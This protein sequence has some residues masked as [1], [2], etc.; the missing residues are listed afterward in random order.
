MASN[1]AIWLQ[2]F[3]EQ[4][5]PLFRNTVHDVLRLTVSDNASVK[6]LADAILRDMTL[7]A[8]VLAVSNSSLY[9]RACPVETITQAIIHIGFKRIREVCLTTR[10]MDAIQVTQA[11]RHTKRVL[12]QAFHSAVQAHAIA[13][14]CGDPDPEEVFI[15]ALLYHLAEMF[16]WSFA[17]PSADAIF[18]E[19]N[20]PGRTP[21]QAQQDLLGTTFRDLTYRLLTGW[22][23]CD[24]LKHIFERTDRENPRHEYI[25]LG[26]K[27]AQSMA[28]TD[29]EIHI[30]LVVKRLSQLLE[31][32]PDGVNNFI[33]GN[34]DGV[35]NIARSFGIRLEQVPGTRPGAKGRDNIAQERESRQSLH[36]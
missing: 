36:S 8:R 12:V 3:N 10:L 1:L 24:L 5:F 21:E 9:R 18:A 15:A 16:F 29:E 31:L 35:S 17:G 6:S 7:T 4:S 25:R 34:R 33:Q 32:S 30:P 14:A 27:I 11:N 19:L 2:H 13:K 26:L 22:H 28:M 20:R 23:I